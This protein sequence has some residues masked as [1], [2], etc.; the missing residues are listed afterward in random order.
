[1]QFAL[2]LKQPWAALL[3]HKHKTIEVRSWRVRP[4]Y[5]GKRILI[6]AARVPDGRPEAWDHVKDKP[7]V[8]QTAQLV[9]GI[10]G[11]GDLKGCVAYRSVEQFAADQ[12]RHRNELAWFEGPVLYGF[13]FENLQVLPFRRYPGWMRFFQVEEDPPV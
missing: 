8:R 13:L 2:S 9:G 6:H 1:M 11:A 10:I 7:E 4:R 5:L 12:A 3:V